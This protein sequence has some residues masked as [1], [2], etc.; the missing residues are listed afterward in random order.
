MSILR[1]ALEAYSRGLVLLGGGCG[2]GGTDAHVHKR[3]ARPSPWQLFAGPKKS[4]ILFYLQKVQLHHRDLHI[5]LAVETS[6]LG[7]PSNASRQQVAISQ[8]IKREF[9]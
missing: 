6:S 8:Q 3:C 9:N 5:I 2:P 7:G 4:K 1:Q